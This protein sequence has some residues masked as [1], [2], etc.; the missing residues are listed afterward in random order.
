M[1][2]PVSKCGKEVCGLQRLLFTSLTS[3]LALLTFPSSPSPAQLKNL[4]GAKNLF[5]AQHPVCATQVPNVTYPHHCATCH[6]G[7]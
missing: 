1:S 3:T 7:M 2:C 6:A 5:G 4:D